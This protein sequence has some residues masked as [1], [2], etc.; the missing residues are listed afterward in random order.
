M[1]ER[2]LTTSYLQLSCWQT[3]TGWLL[4]FDKT[5]CN[6]S[7][8]THR[9]QKWDE[10]HCRRSSTTGRRWSSYSKLQATKKEDVLYK[11]E[12]LEPSL[13]PGHAHLC[14]VPPAWCRDGCTRRT[15]RTGSPQG[16][17]PCRRAVSTA[18]SGTGDSSCSGSSS[19]CA[20]PCPCL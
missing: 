12:S 8:C 11:M 13:R 6:P 5:G 17:G 10:R 1:M 7:V 14:S 4:V 18:T 2:D 19:P 20:A 3:R 15:G 16:P 9:L